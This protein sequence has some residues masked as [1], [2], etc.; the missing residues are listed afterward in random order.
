MLGAG[1][2]VSVA[3]PD[4]HVPDHLLAEDPPPFHPQLHEGIPD[5]FHHGS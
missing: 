4:I 5:P 1:E 2:P 3:L